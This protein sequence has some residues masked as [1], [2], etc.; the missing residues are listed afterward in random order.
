MQTTT[1]SAILTKKGV[2][3]DQSDIHAYI[4]ADTLN[5]PLPDVM[6]NDNKAMVYV[7]VGND[8]ITLDIAH[9]AI[10]A[11]RSHSG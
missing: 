8:V 7:L 5:W 1:S 6:T 11:L 9:E 3:D 4:K 2:R 10:L